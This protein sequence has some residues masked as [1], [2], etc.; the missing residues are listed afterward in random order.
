MSTDPNP[1]LRAE[2]VAAR[3]VLEP[4][5]RGMADTVSLRTSTLTD[6]TRAKVEEGLERRQQRDTLLANAIAAYDNLV[7][8]L[9]TLSDDG[10]PALPKFDVPPAIFTELQGQKSDTV[11]ALDEFEMEPQVAGATFSFPAPTPK[12]PAP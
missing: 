6:A 12:P 1:E 4:Q 8:Q 10:Y 9:I 11:T 2:L 5:I 7:A 3:G